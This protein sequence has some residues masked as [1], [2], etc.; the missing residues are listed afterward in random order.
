MHHSGLPGD[1]ERRPYASSEGRGGG[2]EMTNPLG[3]ELNGGLLKGMS[4]S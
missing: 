2:G 1:S 3:R 4:A